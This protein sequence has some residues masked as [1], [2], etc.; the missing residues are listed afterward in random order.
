[1]AQTSPGDFFA[2]PVPIVGAAGT[3]G[4]TNTLATYEVGEPDHAGKPGGKSVWFT[5]IAPADGIA[6]LRTVGSTFDTLLAVYRGTSVNSLALEDS[7]EDR[8]GFLTS[9]VQFNVVQDTEYR[10]AVDGF[11]GSVGNFILTWLLETNQAL[12]VIVTQP[13]GGTVLEG[14]DF[15]FNVAASGTALAYQWFRGTNVIVG[16]V[17]PSLTVTNVRPIDV[18]AYVVRVSNA[19]ARSVLSQPAVLEIGDAVPVRSRDKLFDLLFN[20]GG[21]QDGGGMG[22]GFGPGFAPASTLSG[23]ASV[24]VGSFQTHVLDNSGAQ[25]EPGEP[26][27]CGS[28]GGSSK[29]FGLTPTEDGLLVINTIG[30]DFD[31]TLAV[32]TGPTNLPASV[33]PGYYYLLLRPVACDSDGGP[34][35]RTSVAAFLAKGGTNYFL[36]IDGAGGAQGNIRLNWHLIE[37]PILPAS[38]DKRMVKLESDVVMFAV[39]TNPPAGTSFRWLHDG[40]NVPGGT[41][42]SHIIAHAQL[43]HGG[44]Y[45]ASVRDGASAPLQVGFGYLIP[46]SLSSARAGSRVMV[47]GQASSGVILDRAVELP[48]WSPVRVIDKPEDARMGFNHS[49]S[50]SPSQPEAFFRLRPYP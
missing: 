5:W 28:I 45:S 38:P 1:V 34:D 9:E 49:E 10:V 4:G 17:G 8:G 19:S 25:S 3:I 27:P 35:G 50:I 15:A 20:T 32:Y 48:I 24:A 23:F 21:T 30:S 39:P 6:T 41:N 44:T 29:W 2:V 43:R 7:D 42:A 14:A 46:A 26:P 36:S 12:P 18:G 37:S 31:T 16:A 22:A 47:K 13:V 40:T 33:D 11:G